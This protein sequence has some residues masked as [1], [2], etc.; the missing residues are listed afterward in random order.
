MHKF[1][2]F[3]SYSDAQSFAQVN[4]PSRIQRSSEG[5][6]VYYD[7]ASE[8]ET[9]SNDTLELL[10]RNLASETDL[11]LKYEQEVNNLRAE[12]SEVRGKIKEKASETRKA[13]R[14]EYI[15]RQKELKERSHAELSRLRDE[16][17]RLA[18]EREKFSEMHEKVQEDFKLIKRALKERFGRFKVTD[19]AEEHEDSFFCSQCGGDGGAAGGCKRCDGTG[20][21]KRVVLTPGR[22]VVFEDLP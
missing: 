4:A 13:L 12:L 19:Y 10:K 17:E 11:R 14:E 20:W 2:L 6:C 16:K 9:T 8:Q 22:R 21:E 7:T 1:R 15:A 18:K 3:S 5:F